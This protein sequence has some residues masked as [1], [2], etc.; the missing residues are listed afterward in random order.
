MSSRV[1]TN[2]L[3][4]ST[5]CRDIFAVFT[6][7]ELV[8]D[9]VELMCEELSDVVTNDTVMIGLDARG[10]ILAPLIARQL[11]LPFVPLRK[12]G[13]LPGKVASVSYAKEYGQDTIEVQTSSL[14]RG[15]KCIIVDDLLA[16]GGT[17]EASARLLASCK[18]KVTQI[19]TLMELTSLKGREKLKGL[20]I[21][22]LIEFD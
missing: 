10:F 15:S 1:D 12:K 21:T 22:S 19:I 3:S 14:K 18:C 6:K 5:T 4:L 2:Y 20:P 9:I 8:N 16:T 17:L 7:P 13:K 11:H